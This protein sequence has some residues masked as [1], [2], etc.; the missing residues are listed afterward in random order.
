[1]VEVDYEHEFSYRAGSDGGL[2]PRLTLRIWSEENP[3]DGLDV[4][5]YLD[6]GAE[7][8]LLDG[9]L[10]RALGID[11]L[12]GP[13][14]RYVGASGAGLSATLHPVLLAHADLGSFRVEVGFSWDEISRNLLG[15]DFFRLIQIGFRESQ[16]L[17]FIR[18]AP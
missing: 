8:T 12:D 7:R 16:G 3:S 17:F 9:R 10:G 14:T 4:D 18:P 15:R 11:I 2:F 13:K 1:M 6:S 5:A